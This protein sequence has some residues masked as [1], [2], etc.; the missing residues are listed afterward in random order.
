MNNRK[1]FRTKVKIDG[2]L[3]FDTAFHIGSGKEG[4]L[5]TN[6]GVMIETD[7]RPI[8]PGSTL[9]GCFRATAERLAA[10]LGLNACLLDYELS[11]ENC[12][13]GLKQEEQKVK[14][15]TFREK[16]EVAK[17]QWLEDNLCDICRLFGSPL[18]AS[19]IFF[20]DGKLAT[21]SN[22]LQIRNGVCIDRDS[23]T[24]RPGPLYDFEV[25]PAGASFKV[26]I[27]LENPAEKE[28]AIVAAVMTE[29]EDGFRLGGFTSRGLGRAKL[30]DKT[31][32]KVDYT[33]PDQLKSYLL[34]REMQTAD[35][36]LSES[37]KKILNKPGG[38]NA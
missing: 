24:A 7:G 13:T 3:T 20:S 27:E 31:I 23:E 35:N 32:H 30:H 19:H 14:Y 18:Q 29:W 9:K 16:T 5:A 21:W 34:N 4:E 12:F 25:V 10:Y 11:G 26:T 28:L 1:Y 36:L 17:L 15:E 8:L 33:D 37:L 38:G 2:T 6:M 22:G